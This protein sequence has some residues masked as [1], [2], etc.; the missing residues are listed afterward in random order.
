[1]C[2]DLLIF[3]IRR[4]H[5][6]GL[7]SHGA[8]ARGSWPNRDPETTRLEICTRDPACALLRSTEREKKVNMKIVHIG[9]ATRYAY[10]KS[11]VCFDAFNW[12]I[13]NRYSTSRNMDTGSRLCFAV[14]NWK[15]IKLHIA[16]TSPVICTRDPACSFWRSTE[17]KNKDNINIVYIRP[18]ICIRDPACVFWISTEKKFIHLCIY[19]YSTHTSSDMYTGSSLRSFV[20]I[21]K[22]KKDY[23]TIVHIRPTICIRDQAWVLLCSDVLVF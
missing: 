12:K 13:Q 5:R 14:F 20:F 21:S 11:S 8:I 18:V 17:K 4:A 3:V 15:K 16:H 1:M 6:A 7:D 19:T 23:M 22:K 10:T 9:S 2:H